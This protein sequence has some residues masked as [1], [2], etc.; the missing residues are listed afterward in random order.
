VREFLDT[1]ER[2]PYNQVV[3]YSLDAVFLLDIYM[4]LLYGITICDVLEFKNSRE[5]WTD[6]GARLND[7]DAIPHAKAGNRW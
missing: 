6:G 5:R 3:D 4:F 1:V 7:S 2:V